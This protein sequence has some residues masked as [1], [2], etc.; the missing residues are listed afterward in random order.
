MAENEDPEQ[1]AATPNGGLQE[2]DVVPLTEKDQ[3]RAW[4]GT[5]NDLITAALPDALKCSS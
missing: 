4:Y 3:E 1:A 2:K 5:P